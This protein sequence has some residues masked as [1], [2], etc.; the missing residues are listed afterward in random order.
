M[1]LEA[2]AH[3]QRRRAAGDLDALDAAPDAAARL[4]DRLAV[5]GRDGPGQLLEVLLEQLDESEQRAGAQDDGRVAPARERRAS[6][7]LD[8]GVEIGARRQRRLSR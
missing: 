5:L 4:V 6:R 7:G 8:G 1:L 3:H 2:V